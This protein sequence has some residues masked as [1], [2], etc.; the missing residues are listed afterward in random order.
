MRSPVAHY[1]DK[2]RVVWQAQV[3]TFPTCA[4]PLH[5]VYLLTRPTDDIS[6]STCLSPRIDSCSQRQAFMALLEQTFRLDVTDSV[7]LVRQMHWLER[8]ISRVPVRRLRIPSDFSA[9][10][11]VRAVV[12]AD[13][14]PLDG[15]GP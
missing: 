5:R 13:R 4:L 15:V 3:T 10:P 12:L 2:Q 7:M 8:L 1:T 14:A 6:V 9:L 11:A